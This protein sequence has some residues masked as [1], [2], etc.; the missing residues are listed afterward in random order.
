MS[1]SGWPARYEIR[2]DGVLDDRRW[3]DW[4]GDLQVSNE[5]TQTV[6]AGLIV[7]QPALHGMLAKIRD[8]GLSLISVRRLEPGDTG[9]QAPQ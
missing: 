9:S 8:L 2:V 5:A 1:G 4:F 7:D 3:A 6:I